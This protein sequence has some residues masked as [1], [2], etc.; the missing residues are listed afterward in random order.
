[1]KIFNRM[2][3]KDVKINQM[4]REIGILLEINNYFQLI[5]T[6]FFIVPWN[7]SFDNANS[8]TCCGTIGSRR[9][10]SAFAYMYLNPRKD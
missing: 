5:F 3:V 4:I 7:S 6:L 10:A 2:N 8:K 1:M 9:I